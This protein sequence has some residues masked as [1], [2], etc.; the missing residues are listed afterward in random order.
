MW[1]RSEVT[2]IRDVP[3]ARGVGEEPKT[4][5]HT[6]RCTVKSIGQKE[7]Y[8]ARALGLMAGVKL[9]LDYSENYFG[10]KRCRFEGRYYR[11]ERTYETETNEIELTLYPENGIARGEVTTDA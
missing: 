5:Q 10:E 1:R 11:I 3:E 2:L 9:V 4:L 6:E 7:H 8:Q